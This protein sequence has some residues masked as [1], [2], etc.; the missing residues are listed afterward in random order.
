MGLWIGTA[1]MYLT[2]ATQL[3]D[4]CPCC[5]SMAII[6]KEGQIVGTRIQ[7]LVIGWS[8]AAAVATAARLFFY[9]AEGAYIRVWGQS[10]QTEQGS[11]TELTDRRA[12]KKEKENGRS[13]LAMHTHVTRDAK[14]RSMGGRSLMQE[15]CIMYQ[16]VTWL[17]GDD[18]STVINS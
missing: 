5:A 2:T 4:K 13:W 8:P 12:T 3:H 15:Y 11:M 1:L 16:K 6:R 7:I 10:R 18:N 9:Y 14:N 17:M